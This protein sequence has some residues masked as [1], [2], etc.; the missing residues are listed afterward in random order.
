MPG[1][2][3]LCDARG[4]LLILDEIYTG[5]GRTGRMF[6]CEHERVVPDLMCIGKAIAGGVPLSA[7]IGRPHV[8]DA[9]AKSEGE[10]LHTSTY[11]GNPLAC[12]AA[13]ANIGELER[14]RVLERVTSRESL[15]EARL[16][17]FLA[18]DTIVDVRGIGFM[19]AL[20]FTSAAEANRVVVDALRRGVILLQSGPTGSSITIAPPLVIEDDQ[21]ARALDSVE[22]S[23]HEKVTR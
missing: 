7:T 11:L 8:M 2:R 20:E 22:A 21:L 6:A 19:W 1:L 15:L 23:I 5:F 9:W 3:A 13:L 10:A 17:K 14:L 4:V 16:R 12:A 18:H